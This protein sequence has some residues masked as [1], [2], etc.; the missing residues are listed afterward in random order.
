[1]GVPFHQWYKW[2]ETRFD[3]LKQVN[4]Q[5]QYHQERQKREQEEILKARQNLEQ[6]RRHVQVQ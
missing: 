4:D 3:Q 5:E 1:M 2:L 6:K